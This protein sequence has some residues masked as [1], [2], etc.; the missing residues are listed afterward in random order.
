VVKVKPGIPGRVGAGLE[1]APIQ[2]S[3]PIEAADTSQA[4]AAAA[5]EHRRL[6][7]RIAALQAKLKVLQQENADLRNTIVVL[8]ANL[9]LLR[10]N[11]VAWIY[12]Q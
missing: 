1:D 11:R 2:T 10:S 9:E 8:N 6:N 4:T 3:R 12:V 7:A 5:R